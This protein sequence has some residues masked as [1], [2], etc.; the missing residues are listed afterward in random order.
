MKELNF[1]K[2]KR[3]VECCY[4]KHLKVHLV[5]FPQS[6]FY[7]HELI[8]SC[9]VLLLEE[10]GIVAQLSEPLTDVLRST[11]YICT[12]LY[13][14]L[15]VRTSG[16]HPVIKV[17]NGPFNPRTY[18]PTYTPRVLQGGGGGLMGPPKGFSSI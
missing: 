3:G 6:L 2:D 15:L 4:Q 9:C 11:F 1:L 7:S 18:K 17:T 10:S 5:C 13:D 12:F 14:H 8:S 16:H